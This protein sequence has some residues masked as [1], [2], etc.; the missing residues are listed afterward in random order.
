MKLPFVFQCIQLYIYSS[1]VFI[2]LNIYLGKDKPKVQVTKFDQIIT[3]S[4]NDA[5]LLRHMLS[6]NILPRWKKKYRSWS[7]LPH[8]RF[9]SSYFY[10]FP[11]ISSPCGVPNAVRH[12]LTLTKRK[13]CVNT[14]ENM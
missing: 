14:S 12:S 5:H 1:F 13:I 10:L 6:H 4:Y 9:F 2:Y 7:I 3:K 8:R 11:P